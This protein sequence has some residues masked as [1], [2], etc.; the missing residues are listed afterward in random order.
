MKPK[1]TRLLLAAWVA[2]GRRQL[3]EEV[4][5]TIH[6]EKDNRRN[7]SPIVHLRTGEGGWSG[8]D[9]PCS[10]HYVSFLSGVELTSFPLRGG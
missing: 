3:L 8:Q 7:V 2:T 5:G 1:T 10:V 6:D 9:S 4:S